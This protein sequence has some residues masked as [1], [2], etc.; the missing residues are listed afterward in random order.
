MHLTNYSL[1]KHNAKKYVHADYESSD[2][3]DTES[4]TSSEDPKPPPAP[5]PAK[6]AFV[7][8]ATSAVLD[9][10]ASKRTLSAV[11]RTLQSQG[12]DVNSVWRHIQGLCARTVIA[13]QDQ[14]QHHLYQCLG[15]RRARHVDKSPCFHILGCVRL[16]QGCVVCVTLN[17]R[18]RLQVGCDA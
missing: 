8:Q 18:C 9:D 2:G 7:G 4:Y 17:E 14:L 1:N 10:H 12:A 3:S 11:L 16:A 6:S 15:K 13:L 5:K